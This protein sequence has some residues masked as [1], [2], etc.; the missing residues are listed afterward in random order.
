MILSHAIR[1]LRVWHSYRVCVHQLSALSDMELADIG[2]TRSAIH[3]V[4]W[5]A[6]GDGA[7]VKPC[8]HAPDI[9]ES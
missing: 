1:A 5:H 8:A 9:N 2:M 7:S 4:A 6:S 3:W